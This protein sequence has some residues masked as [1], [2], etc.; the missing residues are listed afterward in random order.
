MGLVPLVGR[1]P[2]APAPTSPEP[3]PSSPHTRQGGEGGGRGKTSLLPGD[4]RWGSHPTSDGRWRRGP[5]R[6][7]WGC[8]PS[9]CSRARRGSCCIYAGNSRTHAVVPTRRL[10]LVGGQEGEE[11]GRKNQTRSCQQVVDRKRFAEVVDLRIRREARHDVGL[12]PTCAGKVAYPRMGP[13][14]SMTRLVPR[15]GSTSPASAY[16][17]SGRAWPWRVW[18]REGLT[19]FRRSVGWFLGRRSGK[20]VE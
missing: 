12:R 14:R 7:S 19:H 15:C 6:C 1:Y 9:P 13:W 11:V 2:A 17:S 3:T 18:A 16:A 20:G 8:R 10:D 5:R 4:Q